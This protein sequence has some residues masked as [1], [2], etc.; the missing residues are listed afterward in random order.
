[1][2]KKDIKFLSN[3]IE[4]CIQGHIQRPIHYNQVA[5]ILGMQE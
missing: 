5:F 4:N 1:M 3:I 2:I